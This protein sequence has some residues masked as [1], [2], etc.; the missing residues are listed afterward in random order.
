MEPLGK[1]VVITGVSEAKVYLLVE[2]L[3]PALFNYINP[4]IENDRKFR[5]LE[6]KEEADKV[7]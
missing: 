3:Y 5:K 1:L 4:G 7:I 6:G 2:T